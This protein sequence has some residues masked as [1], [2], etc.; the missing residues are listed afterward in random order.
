MNEMHSI[1]LIFYLDYVSNA[2]LIGKPR[3]KGE[4]FQLIFLFN[5]GGFESSVGYFVQLTV[6]VV[7]N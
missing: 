1:S 3:G 7:H 5:R 2:G 4:P 6:T